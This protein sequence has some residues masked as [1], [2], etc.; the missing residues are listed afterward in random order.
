VGATRWTRNN[1]PNY[2]E[3]SHALLGRTVDTGRI[4]DVIAAAKYLAGKSHQEAAAIRVGV[5]GRGPAGILAAYAAVLEPA[6]EAV[7]LL[8]PPTSHRDAEAPPLLNV[9]RVTDIPAALGL[10]APRP[11][12]IR[13]TAAEPFALTR[14]IYEAAGAGSS[15]SLH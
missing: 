5:A 14:E 15:V 6:I 11:L 3:R 1:P 12:R 9:L 2:V 8:D 7:H 13:T 10:L 4:W